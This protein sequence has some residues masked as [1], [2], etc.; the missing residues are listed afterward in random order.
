[1]E[2]I[3]GDACYK[4]V[5]EAMH[6]IHAD[7]KSF[8]SLNVWSSFEEVQD[9]LY[10]Q[11]FGAIGKESGVSNATACGKSCPC[12]TARLGTACFDQ[13]IWFANESYAEDPDNFTNLTEF[14]QIE[15]FQMH[16]WN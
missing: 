7:P 1:M 3:E 15:E 6:A 12:E 14:S 5:V 11:S 2:P 13:V 8:D 10:H 9:Y 4:E 16:L